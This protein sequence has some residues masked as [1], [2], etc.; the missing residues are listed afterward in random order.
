MYPD[1]L[2]FRKSGDGVAVALIDPHGVHLE[3]APLKARG[4][5]RYAQKYGRHFGRI[6]IVIYDREDNREHT[7][8]LKSPT[9]RD[10]VANVTT[11]QHLRSLFDLAGS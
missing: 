4:L 6:E 5:A 9:T 8:N 11:H 7:L 10:E 2:F 1:F 3:D